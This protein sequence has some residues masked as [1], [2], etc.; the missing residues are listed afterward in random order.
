MHLGERLGE[1]GA[2][3]SILLILGRLFHRESLLV[4]VEELEDLRVDNLILVLDGLLLAGLDN[5]DRGEL[6]HL[7]PAAWFCV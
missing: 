3:G 5:E 7:E 4:T 1:P 2:L 6:G